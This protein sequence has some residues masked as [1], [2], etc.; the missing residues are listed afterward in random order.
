MHIYR[1]ETLTF[2]QVFDRI[3]ASSPENL[4]QKRSRAPCSRHRLQDLSARTLCPDGICGQAY[5]ELWNSASGVQVH[6]GRWWKS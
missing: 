2:E 4:I 6:F 1:G 5:A 3:L